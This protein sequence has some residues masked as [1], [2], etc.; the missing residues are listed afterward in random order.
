MGRERGRTVV[1]HVPH[2]TQLKDLPGY[3]GDCLPALIES[4]ADADQLVAGVGG[5]DGVED[6]SE[7]EAEGGR[8]DEAEKGADRR[9]CHAAR[10]DWV[11]AGNLNQGLVDGGVRPCCLWY[12]SF[13]GSRGG[14]FAF[15]VHVEG[16]DVWSAVMRLC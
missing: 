9:L 5:C 11:R 15:R 1:S 16:R 14:V 4:T 7:R 12:R 3:G 2:C 10:G 13:A 6:S 8:E